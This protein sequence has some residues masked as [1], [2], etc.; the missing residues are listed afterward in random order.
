[1]HLGSQLLKK[2]HAPNQGVSVYILRSPVNAYKS[3]QGETQPPP[4]VPPP[5]GKGISHRAE[6][7]RTARRVGHPHRSETG[8]SSTKLGENKSYAPQLKFSRL[9]F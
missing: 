8:P 4:Q 3:S 6:A 7:G 1:M 5:R 2:K 9:L